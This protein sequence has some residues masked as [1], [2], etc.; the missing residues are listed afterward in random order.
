MEEAPPLV[1]QHNE[2]ID[3]DRDNRNIML[4]ENFKQ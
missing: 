4:V 2:D 1:R 3:M